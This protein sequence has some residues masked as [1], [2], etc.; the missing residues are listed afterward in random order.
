MSFCRPTE[1]IGV[2]FLWALI[3]LDFLVLLPATFT[4]KILRGL[5][6]IGCDHFWILA[7]E[8]LAEVFE[9]ALDLF[10]LG[11]ESCELIGGEMGLLEGGA[12]GGFS[13][14]EMFIDQH[15]GGFF[16]CS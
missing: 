14:L 12:D 2:E 8:A 3:L 1:G 9:E 6:L 7:D 4:E 11:E 16:C 5:M 10:G 13:F 15:G